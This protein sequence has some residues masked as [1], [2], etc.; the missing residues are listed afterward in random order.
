MD[1]KAPGKASLVKEIDKKEVK[2]HLSPFEFILS[3]SRRFLSKKTY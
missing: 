2:Q 1:I 3:I